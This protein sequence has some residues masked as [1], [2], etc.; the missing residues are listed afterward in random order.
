M[1]ISQFRLT[2]GVFWSVPAYARALQSLL[3]SS[4]AMWIM[5][6]HLS[7]ILWYRVGSQ[8]LDE[9]RHLHLVDGDAGWWDGGSIQ[10]SCSPPSPLYITVT[11][12]KTDCSYMVQI[13]PWRKLRALA[14]TIYANIHTYV[15]IIYAHK[16]KMVCLNLWKGL[17]KKESFDRPGNGF[18]LYKRF[19]DGAQIH[20]FCRILHPKHF[21]WRISERQVHFKATCRDRH[22]RPRR[23]TRDGI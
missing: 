12:I 2:S 16:K 18:I 5:G 23:G 21:N 15:H 11:I 9:P 3:T 17:L 1:S 8:G 7:S 4:V 6:G 10:C 19:Q 20:A 14:H 13:V 22:Q